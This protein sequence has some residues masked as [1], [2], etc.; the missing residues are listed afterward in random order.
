MSRNYK[1]DLRLREKAKGSERRRNLAKEILK[2]STPLPLPLEYKDIDEAFKKWVEEDLDMSYEGQRLP[3]VSLFSNQRFSEYMQ[4][5]QNVDDKKNLILNFKTITREP[6][7]KPGTLLGQTRTIPGEHKVLLRTVEAYDR[8]DRKY[9]IDYKVKLPYTVDLQY[10]V[11]IVTNKYELLNEFNQLVNDRFKSIDCY[12]RPNGHF[13]PMKLNDISDE[14]EYSIDNRQFYSQSYSIVVMA[15][16][17]RKDDYSVEERP[18]FRFV[19]FEGERKGTFAEIEEVPCVNPQ[20]FEFQPVDITVNFVSCQ[21][22]YKFRIDSDFQAD[23]FDLDNVRCFRIFVNDVETTL[24]ENFRVVAG[25]EI[26]IN[27]IVRY[28]VFK[29]SKIIIHG[30]YTDRTYM[31]DEGTEVIDLDTES[32]E[33]D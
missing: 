22:S 7:P 9:F 27:H 14:S 32:I 13:V 30:H 10:T 11:S 20:K 4:S 5:W 26:K 15:Y 17:I 3:T 25:D 18:D 8:N 19:G 23:S 29:D 33:T 2:D 12:I 21:T 24:D 31:V 6:N 28:H 1:N 16:I